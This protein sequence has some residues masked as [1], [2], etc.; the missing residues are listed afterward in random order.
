MTTHVNGRVVVGL[1]D[2]LGVAVAIVV[3]SAT[4]VQGLPG[5]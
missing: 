4:I 3:T 5:S 1:W 2:F